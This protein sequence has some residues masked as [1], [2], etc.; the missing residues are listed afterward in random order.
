M[1]GMGP[2]NIWFVFGGG[3]A[4]L[5][6]SKPPRHFVPNWPISMQFGPNAV[7]S[8][9]Q[10]LVAGM[11]ER[12]GRWRGG[13]L[14]GIE[15]DMKWYGYGGDCG[16]AA[17]CK[18]HLH[19]T[20]RQCNKKA[21]GPPTASTGPPRIAERFGNYLGISQSPR[22]PPPHRKK[23]SQPHCGSPYGCG[24]SIAGQSSGSG[25]VMW[26]ICT[27]LATECVERAPQPPR[28]DPQW[29]WEGLFLRGGG[30]GGD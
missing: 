24:G 21:F 23:P 11:H 14:R 29:G 6:W 13:G 1:G 17:W 7:W 12:S 16:P 30:L 15:T 27:L 10:R 3:C 28:S 19:F 18:E 25:G 20:F 4:P 2:A 5:A 26:A 9:F 8:H 22:N